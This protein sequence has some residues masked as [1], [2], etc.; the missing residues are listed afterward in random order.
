[1]LPKTYNKR[2]KLTTKKKKQSLSTKVIPD[3]VTEL[4]EKLTDSLSNCSEDE[5]DLILEE[6]EDEEDEEP[7]VE[8]TVEA[9]EEDNVESLEAKKVRTRRKYSFRKK[10]ESKAAID[11]YIRTQTHYGYRINKNNGEV[12]CTAC[13]KNFDKHLMKQEWLTCKCG[14]DSCILAW[15]INCCPL[16][17]DKWNLYQSGDFHTVDHDFACSVRVIGK[18]P[19]ARYGVALAVREF[20]N[21]WL[22]KNNRMTAFDL[23]SKLID[24]RFKNSQLED[25]KKCERLNFSERLIPTLKQTQAFVRQYRKANG[26]NSPESVEKLVK[27]HSYR[28]NIPDDEPFF[29]NYE[30]DDNYIQL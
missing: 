24:K 21:K 8:K 30:K 29:F 28:E 11:K 1:M 27:E 15:K 12:N 17:G 14:A 23:R 5:I 7:F 2:T 25:D 13:S 4:F 16:S 22:A 26:I 3:N 9:S 10:F 18:K 20:Y 6:D 19:R